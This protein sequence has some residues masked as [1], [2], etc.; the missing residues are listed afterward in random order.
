MA[1]LGN[2][3]RSKGFWN[4]VMDARLMKQYR[5]GSIW[6]RMDIKGAV[7]ARLAHGGRSS[8]RG[9]KIDGNADELEPNTIECW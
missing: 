2:S 4:V 1:S 9:S 5:L 6:C 8:G 3:K 7:V